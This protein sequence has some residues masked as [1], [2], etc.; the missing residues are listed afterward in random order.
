MDRQTG[1]K[2]KIQKNQYWQS[3]LLF[4][5]AAI[6]TLGA[7]SSALAQKSVTAKFPK[8]DFS[9]MEEYYE[10]VDYEYDYASGGIG[11]FYVTAKK[12]QQKVPTWFDI[13]WRDDKGVKLGDFY[14]MF[15]YY[16][17]KDAKIGETVRGSATAPEYK[18]IPKIKSVMIV[19][20]EDPH[21][22][23]KIDADKTFLASLLDLNQYP[24]ADFAIK[25][26]E[27]R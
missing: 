7:A 1:V 13:T 26:N 5:I 25:T 14:L 3:L 8:P 17:M 15:E 2:M 21:W 23:G 18:L 11:K 6:I 16:Y 12:K 10:I 19:E 24:S 9:A 4:T 20:S 22:L 27:E